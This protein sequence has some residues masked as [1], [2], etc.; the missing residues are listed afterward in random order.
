MNICIRT[1]SQSHNI[2][3]W[4][5]WSANLKNPHL[6][7]LSFSTAL[8]KHQYWVSKKFNCVFS[9]LP[10]NNIAIKY[11]FLPKGL[12]IKCQF[13]EV[14]S[15]T[16]VKIHNILWTRTLGDQMWRWAIS[17]ND[18]FIPLVVR[19][20]IPLQCWWGWCRRR[21]LVVFPIFEQIWITQIQT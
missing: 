5:C 1:I 17:T 20:I 19:M 7:L 14:V 21:K 18:N 13:W 2:W 15:H 10:K 12:C 11:Q 4:F 8:S 6:L 9:T 3:K 16:K